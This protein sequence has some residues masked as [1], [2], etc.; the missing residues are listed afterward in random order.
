MRK[1]NWDGV[2]NCMFCDCVETVSH[3][4]FFSVLLQELFG[5][6]WPYV[7]GLAI[8]QNLLN[9]A[10]FGVKNGFKMEKY[11]MYG[12]LGPSVGNMEM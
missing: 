11:F 5:L 7:L 3:L 4:F 1:R 6:F 10:G 2:P 12:G 8:Y 9:N